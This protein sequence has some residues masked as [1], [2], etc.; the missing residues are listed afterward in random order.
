MSAEPDKVRLKLTEVEQSM[1]RDLGKGGTVEYTSDKHS[2]DLEPG[3]PVRADLASL[4]VGNRTTPV[5]VHS[6]EGWHVSNMFPNYIRAPNGAE[7]K[8]VS[9]LYKGNEDGYLNITLSLMSDRSLNVNG[10][11][12]WWDIAIAGCKESCGVLPMVIFNDKVSPP[13]LGFLA[14]YGIMGLYVSVV[15]VIG[16]F[17]RGF[18]SEISHSI[19]FEELPCVDRILKL[20]TDIFLVRETGELE[21]EE[22]LYSKLIF[23]YRSPETMIKWTRDIHSQDRY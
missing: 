21:L 5:Y 22:E 6:L 14:G 3:N 13:S 9:Q 19:M 11:Q 7:A 18:F 16:K 12:E 15:L 1:S 20:C 8:P 4:L 17:V 10:N 23:L 2:I